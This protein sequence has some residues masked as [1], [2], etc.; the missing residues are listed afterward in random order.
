M[1]FYAFTTDQLLFNNMSLN[2]DVRHSALL[3]LDN[4]YLASSAFDSKIPGC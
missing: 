1:G 2:N 3:M 4:Q